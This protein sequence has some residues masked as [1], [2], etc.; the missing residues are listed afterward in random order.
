MHTS[1]AQE[2]GVRTR[3]H[4]Q[5]RPLLITLYVSFLPSWLQHSLPTVFLSGLYD[6]LDPIGDFGLRSPET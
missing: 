4:P 1:L 6:N 3:L 5:H 2:S